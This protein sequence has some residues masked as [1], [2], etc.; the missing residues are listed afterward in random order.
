MNQLADEVQANPD[1]FENS[2]RLWARF[3]NE[4]AFSPSIQAEFELIRLSVPAQFILAGWYGYFDQRAKELLDRSDLCDL[5][6]SSL[7]ELHNIKR[8][9]AAFDGTF[10]APATQTRRAIRLN[11]SALTIGVDLRP[12]SIPSSRNRGIGRY[13]INTLPR[14]IARAGRHKFV[15][16]TEPGEKRDE[17]LLS[18]FSRNDLIFRDFSL[19]CDHDLDLF[20]L[21]DPTPMLT[22]K[23]LA[24]LPVTQ[25]AWMSIVY[26]F[27]PLEYPELYLRGSDQ[28]IDE[29]LGNFELI[30]ERCQAVFPISRYVA[31]QC[32]VLLNF[33][34]ERVIPIFGGVDESFFEVSSASTLREYP[35][36]YFLYV[37][38]ADARKNLAGLVK[39]FAVASSE[40]PA[41]WKLVLVG[42]MNSDKTAKM[43]RDMHL[44]N[45]IGRVVGLGG[46][47][48][49]RLRGLYAN[50]LATVFVSHSEG[51]GLP[52]LEAMATGCP[53]IASKTT[54]LGET[55]G[56]TGILVDPAST[57]E[58]AQGMLRIA[59][60]SSL[61]NDLAVRGPLH[62]RKWCWDDV[63]AC[64]LNGIEKF[65]CR[66]VHSVSRKRRMRVAMMNRENVWSALGGDSR[67]MLQMQEA[68]ALADVEVYFPSS[69]DQAS[70]ADLI[71]FVNMTLPAPLKDATNFSQQRN[72]PLLVTT[73]YEDW[74]QYLNASHQAFSIYRAFMAG[75]SSHLSMV[76]AL[77]NL[78]A[79]QPAPQLDVAESLK[80]ATLL[81]AC[82]ESEAMRLQQD[83]PY[84]EDRILVVPFE[85]N[86]PLPTVQRMNDSLRNALGF[87]EFVLCIGRLE[88]RKNQLALLT[89]LHDVDIPIV[90]ASGSYTPQPVYSQAVRAWRRKAPVK[91]VDRMPWHLMSALI[92]S[93]SA[94]VLPSFYEL[95]GLVHLECAAAGIPIVAGEWGAISDYL[96]RSVFHACDPLNLESIRLAT[97]NAL[98]APLAPSAA[99]IAMSYTRERLA[100]CLIN[101]YER[102]LIESAQNVNRSKQYVYRPLRPEATGGIHAAV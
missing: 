89:A 66:E 96:P 31:N 57:T 53:V 15:L 62:A 47:D 6:S 37:G 63:S 86:I 97:L 52:A 61:R 14:L 2:Q 78:R 46:I 93:A 87:D 94:H 68:A 32:E 76:T 58:I 80:H 79:S 24:D 44:E 16:L 72:I 50:A 10:R 33:A 43:L 5:D 59:K 48:D 77:D 28:L 13:L 17:E 74:P 70:T 21:S 92:R 75:Q 98:N 22:G 51:L 18:L 4:A 8:R 95:P 69:L 35:E 19:G 55:V 27:I 11:T 91:F 39:A 88:T 38:G 42:E 73:L 81:L 60:D 49:A 54:A 85:V 36:P 45:Y 101:S 3:Y 83:Y 23:R 7:L 56:S 30:A 64:L 20:L 71:H 84:L 12:L 99:D 25:C 9:C 34:S 100:S 102:A 65:A 40:M 26:D 1:R 90:F 41:E 29:Y 67:I 82:A